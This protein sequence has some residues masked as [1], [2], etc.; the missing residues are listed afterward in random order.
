MV[1]YTPEQQTQIINLEKQKVQNSINEIQKEYSTRESR[2]QELN[3]LI[4][5]SRSP[6]GYINEFKNQNEAMIQ[7]QKEKQVLANSLGKIEQGSTY[8]DV[9]RYAGE[10]GYQELYNIQ[11]AQQDYQNKSQ[12]QAQQNNTKIPNQ[13]SLTQEQLKGLSPGVL[14]DLLK[15]GT[16]NGSNGNLNFDY[17]TEINREINLAIQRGDIQQFSGQLYTNTDIA[18]AKLLNKVT[19]SEVPNQ[20][21]EYMKGVTPEGIKLLNK[22]NAQEK[23]KLKPSE[24]LVYNL[25]KPYVVP[26][27]FNLINRKD[28]IANS[29]MIQPITAEDLATVSAGV[30]G[31]AN[32]G[33]LLGTEI[34]LSKPI[35]E[36]NQKVIDNLIPR[37]D[38][39][40]AISGVIKQI[41]R[42]GL[43]LATSPFTEVAYGTELGKGIITNPKGTYEGLK[44]YSTKNPYEIATISLGA[45]PIEKITDISLFGKKP[46]KFEPTIEMEKS[47][48]S[49]NR[50]TS[51]LF[52]K[53]IKGNY[54][55]G[56]SGNEYISIGGGIEKGQTPLKTIEAELRQETG[57]LLKDIKN[58]KS[59]GKVVFPEETMNIFTGEIKDINKIKPS[60]DIDKIGTVNPNSLLVKG[61]KGQ[62]YLNPISRIALIKTE[63][64]GGIIGI[65][66]IGKIRSY[67]SGVINYLEKGIKPTWLAI[68]T[69]LGRYFLGTQSR[70]NVPFG[71][72]K[73]F[74][75]NEELLLAHGTANP[76]ILRR[77]YPFEKSDVI[78]GELTRRGQAEGLYLQPPISAEKGSAGY[79]G[80]SYLGFKTSQAVDYLGIKFGKYKPTVYSFKEIAKDEIGPTPKT[81]SGMEEELIISP[82]TKIKS[83]GRAE[84]FSIGLKRVY[85]Q[86]SEILRDSLR[87]DEEFKK[88]IKSISEEGNYKYVST[89]TILPL[90]LN[91]SDISKS[92]DSNIKSMISSIGKSFSNIKSSNIKSSNYSNIKSEH[93]TSKLT[94]SKMSESNIDKNKYY[95]SNSISKSISKFQK[96]ISKSINSISI[97]NSNSKSIS[98]IEKNIPRLPIIFKPIEQKSQVK[99]SLGQGYDV[100]GKVLKSSKF[101]K[102]NSSPV[103]RG[104]AE[105]IGSYYVS[106]TLARS[107]KIVKTSRSAEQDQFYYIPVDYHKYVSNQIREFNIKKGKAYNVGEIFIQKNPFLLN[108]PGEKRQ[109]KAFQNQVKNIL[110]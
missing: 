56:K 71:S 28:Y 65:G 107:F 13:I 45:K 3:K 77:Y 43:F 44:E 19:G 92:I 89:K 17:N 57:L 26:E 110:R 14:K 72:Q 69:D 18:K 4:N 1:D 94:A 2:L 93:S 46:Y 80:M 76:S 52:L 61:V 34:L 8:E 58:F 60:S 50:Q 21:G 33:V 96:D 97:S 74:L 27:K 16:P 104:R 54:I 87:I 55:L 9:Q 11:K 35:T 79:I 31:L 67:E 83:K 99:K 6:Q 81:F 62:T 39:G 64:I 106:N 109:I 29:G 100:Y 105:D 47:V 85:V 66:E 73:K 86:P 36:I 49:F 15:Y 91:N 88:T 68:D 98:K 103:T 102:I 84:V 32:G 101:S 51:R 42:G 25:P 7:L 22:Y 108:T 95:N 59:K 30:Y 70:Y 53:D 48:E 63:N 90:T 5:E 23:A 38:T 20:Y 40:F 82:G 12:S 78:K 75:N 37:Q 41:E 24:Q 10:L